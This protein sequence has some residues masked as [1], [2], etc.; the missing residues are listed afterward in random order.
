MKK[1]LLLLIL[2][3]IT[4]GCSNVQS[5]KPENITVH[6]KR[7]AN[8]PHDIYIYYYKDENTNVADWPGVLMKYEKADWYVY[9]ISESWYKE[10]KVMFF[11]DDEHRNPQHLEP[12]FDIWKIGNGKE[13]W[14]SNSNWYYKNPD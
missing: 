2:I 3:F 5:K 4:V 8:W 6:F 9:T 7:P 13:L 10:S 1:L 14:F 11:G 12:G